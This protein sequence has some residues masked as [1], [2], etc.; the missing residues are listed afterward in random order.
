MRHAANCYID[1]LRQSPST[2]SAFVPGLCSSWWVKGQAKSVPHCSFHCSSSSREYKTRRDWEDKGSYRVPL[3]SILH[4]KGAKWQWCKHLLLLLLPR[5]MPARLGLQRILGH[6]GHG[7]VIDTQRI[8]TVWAKMVCVD[9][10]T[11]HYIVMLLVSLCQYDL[12]CQRLLSGIIACTTF[13]R[14]CML[15][16]H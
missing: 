5:H 15:V 1:P 7:T 4:F 11:E 3:M 6:C 16:P 8:D 13:R 12:A 9:Q 2:S 10:N 14:L